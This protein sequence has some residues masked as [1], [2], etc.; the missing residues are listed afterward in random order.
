MRIEFVVSG[1]ADHW[2][3]RRGHT[4]ALRYESWDRALRAAENLA[5]AAADAGDHAVVT[6][7]RDGGVPESRVF[8]PAPRRRIEVAPAGR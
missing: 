6:L 8:A 2:T 7:L 3:V 4:R 5:R 1:Y